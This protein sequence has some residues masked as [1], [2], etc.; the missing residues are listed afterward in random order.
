MAVKPASVTAL[1]PFCVG[2]GIGGGAGVA[3]GI[4]ADLVAE[5][6]TEKVVDGRVQGAAHQVPEGDFDTADGG[7]GGAASGAFAGEA[8][9]QHFVDLA[10]VEGVFANDDGGG[11]V[12]QLGDADTPVGLTEPGDAFVGFDADQDPWEIAVDDGCADRCDLHELPTPANNPVDRS[13]SPRDPG[14]QSF[15][16]HVA[17]GFGLSR[18]IPYGG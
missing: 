15:S 9:D 5:A 12:H 14:P 10:D 4:D 7:D 3:V 13:V 6:A 11:F 18:T 16:S 17:K 8:A 1:A 2:G